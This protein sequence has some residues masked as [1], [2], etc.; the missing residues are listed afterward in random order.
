[1]PEEYGCPEWLRRNYPEPSPK[2][3]KRKAA[4]TTREVIEALALE[5]MD[6]RA[7]LAEYRAPEPLP[8]VAFKGPHDTDASMFEDMARRL[9]AG[10]GAGGSNP[11]RALVALIR[12][13]VQR[14]SR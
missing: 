7:E 8:V 10:Y 11:T 5:V 13:E 4:L 14:A 2:K 3:T 12:R 6:L 9:D 1:M